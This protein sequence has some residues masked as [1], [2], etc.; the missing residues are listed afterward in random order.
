M[1]RRPVDGGLYHIIKKNCPKGIHWQRIE[2][3]MTAAGVPDLNG[4]YNGQEVW[5]ELKCVSAGQKIRSLTAYQI[6]WM[7][8]RSGKAGGNCWLCILNLKEKNDP[9]IVLYSASQLVFVQDMG[10][11]CLPKLRF[12]IFDPEGWKTFT[13]YIFMRREPPISVF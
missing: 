3:G 1:T 9:K 5:I 7:M 13:D 10:L 11:R 6:G 4:C 12:S 2:T 8:K